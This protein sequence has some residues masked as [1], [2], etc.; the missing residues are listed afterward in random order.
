M[1]R[2]EDEKKY[3]DSVVSWYYSGPSNLVYAECGSIGGFNRF[4]IE[5]DGTIVLYAGTIPA[6]RFFTN[7]EVQSTSRI[8]PIKSD[9]CDGDEIM[10]DGARCAM[11]DI[12]IMGP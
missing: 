7:C 2:C 6:A 5:A 10:V 11:M 8:L 3:P 1:R 12:K 4:T 9:V